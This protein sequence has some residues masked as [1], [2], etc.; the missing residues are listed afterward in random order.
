MTSKASYSK[1]AYFF[2]DEGNAAGGVTSVFKKHI[3]TQTESFNRLVPLDV[4][5]PYRA[6]RVRVIPPISIM[7]TCVA[8][9]RIPYNLRSSIGCIV[10][11]AR[12]HVGLPLVQRDRDDPSMDR[13]ALSVRRLV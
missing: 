4:V 8:Q 12:T 7:P 6:P 5:K 10:V 9:T 1:F 13:V 3:R 2:V 11:T